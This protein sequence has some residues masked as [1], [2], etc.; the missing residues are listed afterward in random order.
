MISCKECEKTVVLFKGGNC[1]S[2]AWTKTV[3]L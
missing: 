3:E 2:L 1:V